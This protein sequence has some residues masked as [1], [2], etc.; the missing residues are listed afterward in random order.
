MRDDFATN[1]S[2][3][4]QARRREAAVRL[5]WFSVAKCE[6]S[7]LTAG[8][9]LTAMLLSR[10]CFALVSLVA[11]AHTQAF[12]TLEQGTGAADSVPPGQLLVATPRMGDPRFAGTVLVMIQHGIEGALGVAINRP[13]ADRPIAEMLRAIGEDPGHAKGSI[14]VFLGGPVEPSVGIVV[15]T[16]DYHLAATLVLDDHLAVTSPQLVLRDIAAGH[17]P[18]KYLFLLGYAGWAPNQLE[19]EL[20]LG[21]WVGVSESPELV[22]DM[23]RAKVWKAAFERRTTSL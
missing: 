23:D 18:R 13:I 20:S 16:R 5:R 8:R 9:E 12:A 1:A 17:G 6:Q 3:W 21:A 15:H 11:T 2:A 7:C 4:M 10:R 14:T 22:F 19:A